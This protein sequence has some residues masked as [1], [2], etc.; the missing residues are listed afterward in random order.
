M[1]MIKKIIDVVNF[2]ADAS[3][4]SSSNWL[5]FLENGSDSALYQ[6]LQNYVR[7]EKKVSLGFTAA[8]ISDI[9]NFNPESIDL[10]NSNTNIFEIILRPYSHDM[11]L[12][13]SKHGF[14]VNLDFGKKI[15]EKEFKKYTSYYLPPE[16]ML[17]NEQLFLLNQNNVD[18]TF[19]KPMRFTKEIKSRIPNKPY[20]VKGLFD[21]SLNCISFNEHSYHAYLQTIQI[22]DQSWND[23][24]LSQEDDWIF[25]WRD[26]ESA[27]FLTEPVAREA[28]W[29]KEESSKIQRFF[30]HEALPEISFE[31]NELL[32]ET[33]YHYY[34]VHS[35][36]PWLREMKMIGF[37]TRLHAFESKIP[38]CSQEEIYWWLQA[39]NSDILSAV[40][41]SSPI[42]QVK[43]HKNDLTSHEHYIWRSERGMEGEE[44]L[45]SLEF[46]INTDA[47]QN[48]LKGSKSKH[49]TKL[50]AR[51]KYLH[52][53]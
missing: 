53:L 3:C 1:V 24:I 38:L 52:N 2:N 18:G 4:L 11:G 19:I 43:N 39:I 7:Y 13:R 37:M 32:G 12:L 17:T 22:F 44:I 27:F 23:L 5:S 50:N 40:E 26:G 8:T 16:F 48:Y 35:I 47:I 41:K 31:N 34:P 46:G 6:W 33:H 42:I 9:A 15:I 14:E 25:S 30:L 21:S 29:L 20:K 45:S 28:Q 10:I 36:S 49:I 51:V